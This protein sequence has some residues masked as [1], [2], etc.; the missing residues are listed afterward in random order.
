M[1]RRFKP[2]LDE[3]LPAQQDETTTANIVYT[4]FGSGT[5]NEYVEKQGTIS[6]YT[7][8][9]TWGEW[10]QRASLTQWA[11]INQKYIDL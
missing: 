11:D 5:K 4:R 9:W 1:S 10:S 3:L 6:P 2:N 7:H 8:E